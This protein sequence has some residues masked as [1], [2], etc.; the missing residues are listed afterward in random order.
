MPWT[1]GRFSDWPKDAAEQIPLPDL[2]RMYEAGYKGADQNEAA[3]EEFLRVMQDPDG[4]RVAH[5]YGLADNGADKLVI[6]FI[7]ILGLYPGGLPGAAQERG[8]CVSHGTKNAALL[9]MCCDIVA[10]KPDEV[11]GQIEG[12]PEV[13]EEGIK[14]GVLS[15]ETFYWYRGYNGDGWY[16]AAGATVATKKSGL[17]V[18]KSYPELGI[19]LTRYS[20]RNAGLY[21]S[22]AP[23]SEIQA[24]GKL[25]LIHQATELSSFEEI[26]DFL[27]SGY[28]IS[29]CGSEGFSSS[30]NEDGVSERRGS[31]AHA[32]AYIG[33]DDRPSTKQKYGG[34]L[35]LILNSWGP[36]WNSGPTRIMGTNIDIPPGSFWA[37]WK[38]I[39]GREAFAF[40]GTNGF[41]ARTFIWDT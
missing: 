25:H 27:A 7:H 23:G 9:T 26:R 37:R 28:G 13:P 32:M 29:S 11:S 41:P 35:V 19:D 8:D 31:W 33:A 14:Q 18:R 22:R 1:P 15:S 3:Y 38:D 5:Q 21:G 40:S 24:A 10:G 4:Y 36:T 17:F 39:K 30:R 34:P 12:P 2:I 16:C 6:P 20:G